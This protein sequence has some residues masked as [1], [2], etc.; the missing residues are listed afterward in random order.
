M[1]HPDACVCVCFTAMPAYLLTMFCFFRFFPVS[2]RLWVCGMFFGQLSSLFNAQH[3][4]SP[5]QSHSSRR[6]SISHLTKHIPSASSAVRCASSSTKKA[7]CNCRRKLKMNLAG[8]APIHLVSNVQKPQ[9]PKE[10][11]KGWHGALFDRAVSDPQH[12]CKRLR[13]HL[14]LWS[15]GRSDDT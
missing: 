8:F 6:N 9:W 11:E 14:H 15:L 10:G 3:A 2:M 1:R 13:V 7:V 12:F 5:I 4:H